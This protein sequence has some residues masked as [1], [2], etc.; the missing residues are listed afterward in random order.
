MVGPSAP[1]RSPRSTSKHPRLGRPHSRVA[2]LT[3]CASTAARGT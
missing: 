1:A 3:G 2:S